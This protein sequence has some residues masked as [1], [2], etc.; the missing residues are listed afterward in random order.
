ML[1]FNDLGKSN[2]VAAKLETNTLAVVDSL[3]GRYV[4]V[5]RIEE[6]HLCVTTCAGTAE[7]GGNSTVSGNRCRIH[8]WC[9]DLYRYVDRL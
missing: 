8:I 4:F 7:Y 1:S 3:C 2:A 6:E 5:R 9:N